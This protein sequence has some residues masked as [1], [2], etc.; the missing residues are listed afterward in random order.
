[1]NNNYDPFEEDPNAATNLT[2]TQRLDKLKFGKWHVFLVV[3]LGKFFNYY[4]IIH[5]YSVHIIKSNID[6]L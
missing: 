6:A 5:L 4:I 1:M 2:I 3:S